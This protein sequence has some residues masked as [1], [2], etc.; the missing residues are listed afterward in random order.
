MVHN[1]QNCGKLPH[2]WQSADVRY[3]ETARWFNVHGNA[4]TQRYGSD[5]VENS[6]VSDN[7]QCPLLWNGSLI[8]FHGNA[9]T[10]RYRSDHVENSHM[11]D[12]G[13]CPLLWNSSL[14]SFHGNALATTGLVPI[15][16]RGALLSSLLVQVNV[17][18]T[19][20]LLNVLVQIANKLG[21]KKNSNAQT[22]HYGSD[23]AGNSHVSDNRQRQLIWNGSLISFHSNAQTQRYRSI[24]TSTS[25]QNHWFCRICPFFGPPLWSSGQS[26]WLQIRRPRF[27]SRHYQKKKCSRS[28]TGCT[29][30]RE[31]KLRSY[32]IEK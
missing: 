1:N 11:S 3:F 21:I 9:Q 14:I 28:G 15:G 22:Q 30:P 7:R 25:P 29:Q 12:K 23:H 6:H 18:V 8:S 19:H 2:Q 16:Y 4:Q 24:S 17:Y 26:S 5:H 27:D 10:Q 32:L 31:Y 20:N 13:R